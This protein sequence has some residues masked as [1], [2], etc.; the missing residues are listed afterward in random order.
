MP[1]T[2]SGTSG[3]DMLYGTA[4]DDIVFGLGGDD[5]IDG[6]GGSDKIYGGDGNDQIYT[7]GLD[8][9]VTLSFFG[10]NGDDSL[11]GGAGRDFL[12]GGAGRDNLFGGEGA[13]DLRGGAGDDTISGSAGNDRLAGGTG[14]DDLDGASGTD[15]LAGNAGDDVFNGYDGGDIFDGTDAGQ[16]HDVADYWNVSGIKVNL[17]KGIAL[18]ASGA[19]D[20]LIDIEVARG[21]PVTD[22][23]IG[24]NPHNTSYEAFYGGNGADTIDGGWGFDMWLSRNWYTG[25][26]GITA[27]LGKNRIQD[28]DGAWDIARN[29]EGVEGTAN[30]DVFKGNSA[31]NFFI[32]YAGDDLVDGHNGSDTVDF[33]GSTYHLLDGLNIDLAGGTAE[34]AGTKTLRSIENVIG[35]ELNDRIAGTAGANNLSGGLGNDVISGLAAMTASPEIPAPTVFL[36]AGERMYSSSRGREVTTRFPTSQTIL[37][38]SIFPPLVLAT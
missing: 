38:G 26:N 13:D 27:L 35:S 28:G 2:I 29:I 3:P 25:D 9:S 20:K 19:S 4:G 24:G 31:G 7:Y 17:Q 37:T 11:Q 12:S 1:V 30:D 22:I 8:P 18:Y 14:N 10:E 33:R 16:W 15:R 5:D 32:T 36:A 34:G 6:H 23:L 21:T